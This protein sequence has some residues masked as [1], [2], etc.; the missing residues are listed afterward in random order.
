MTTDQSG[1]YKV[2]CSEDSSYYMVISNNESYD[3][4][5][6]C[7]LAGKTFSAKNNGEQFICEDPAIIC[8]SLTNCPN[9]CHYRLK[10][11]KINF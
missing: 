9:D 5:F 3:V 10:F 1:C 11:I 4:E 8:K 7:D 2:N 6:K